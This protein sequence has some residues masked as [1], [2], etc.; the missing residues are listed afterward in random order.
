VAAIILT[1]SGGR[2][3][4]AQEGSAAQQEPLNP[5]DQR[6]QLRRPLSADT[7]APLGGAGTTALAGEL[8]ALDQR[9]RI[10]Q[11]QLEL[12]RER[13]AEV[14]KTVATV[15][16]GDQGFSIRSG[17]GNFQLNF[18]TLLHADGRFFGGD[19][20]DGIADTF[21]AQRVRPYIDAT[22]FR[23]FDVRITPDF[24]QGRTVLQDAYV[25]LRFR[26]ELRLRA[27]KFKAPLGLERLASASDLQFI[28][29]GLP[30]TVAPNRDVGLMVH[31]DVLAT[32]VSYAAGVFNGVA[33]GGSADGDDRDSK[34][35]VARL[36]A[37]P[38]RRTARKTL[39]GLGL[40]LAASYGHQ[41]GA[42]ASPALGSYRTSG[43]VF[44][45]YR[46]DATA[47]GTVLADGAHLRISPQGYYYHRRLG[48]LAE[49]VF[50]SQ[51]VRRAAAVARIGVTAWQV[52][53]SWVLTG[54]DASYRGVTP[55]HAFEA[56][57]GS[58][59]AF[60]IV[61]RYNQLTIDRDAFPIFAAPGSSSQ[62]SRALGGGVN[63]YLN[64]A[65]KLSADYEHVRFTGGAPSGSRPDEH[66]FLT[67]VQFR[68]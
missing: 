5:P 14:S 27:G 63:W 12:A 59:G 30:S 35:V 17:D 37:H 13:E 52:S 68:L 23:F 67:R 44:F 22:M 61:A 39:E 10:I 42:L 9:V 56:S 41:R 26:P 40:G 28:D 6:T 1:L 4:P 65:L 25:D 31:G 49:H 2:A 8:E 32:R 60:E 20:Q 3:L 47:P 7:G 24:G 38:F 43:Q 51:Q 53:G 54:E 46:N 19:R 36:F 15:A 57:R 11:R 48:V 45:R 29:R 62:A 18:R 58:W 64:T 21:V 55:R 33:D 34:E 66:A 16:A 50:S